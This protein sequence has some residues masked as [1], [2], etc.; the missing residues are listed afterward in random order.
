MTKFNNRFGDETKTEWLTP[1]DILQALGHFDLDPCA[2]ISSP[3]KIA[4]KHFTVA[5]NGFIKPCTGRVFLNPPY[6]KD[7]WRWIKRL[8]E[9]GNGIALIF[10]RT[11]T[12]AF[13]P[14]VWFQADGIFFFSKRLDFY[15]VTG[16]K[17][18]SN[19]GAPSVL[20]AYGK[21]NAQILESLEETGK[22]NGKFIKI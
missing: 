22:L 15:H 19:S 4:D 12:K 6:T 3:W 14:Y 1:P 10:A 16:E 13:F 2:P 17:G 21:E 5:D 9:H 7:V 8:S 11:E 18:K 20:I